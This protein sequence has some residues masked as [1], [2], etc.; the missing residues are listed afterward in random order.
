MLPVTVLYPFVSF[1]AA[2]EHVAMILMAMLGSIQNIAVNFTF[3]SGNVLVNEAA[4]KPELKAQIGSVNGAGHM[5]ASAVR[6][7]GPAVAGSLW[8]IITATDMAGGVFVPFA[9]CFA[10]AIATMQLY[11]FI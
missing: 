1:M 10:L 2:Q 11:A 4:S 5:L 9:I 8:S 7:I 6:G 3:A